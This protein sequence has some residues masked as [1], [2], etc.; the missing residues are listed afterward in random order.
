MKDF[1][2]PSGQGANRAGGFE[3]REQSSD[4]R[5]PR[6]SFDNRG[7]Y[8]KY[9]ASRDSG[10][11]REVKHQAT[12]SEC[13]NTCEVPFRPNGSKPVYCK[14]CFG[15][16]KGAYPESAPR[17]DFAPKSSQA[18]VMREEKSRAESRDGRIDELKAQMDSMNAKLDRIMKAMEGNTSKPEQKEEKKVAPA[19]A[20]KIVQKSVA[21]SATKAPVKSTAKA[22][23]KAKPVSKKKK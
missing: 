7:G 21:K 4:F 3:R 1:R 9:S 10:E 22:T 6:P 15:K 18:P 13:N 2:R 19:P 17:N 8:N 11:R 5:A 12:C 16:K 23:V 20:V 14:N